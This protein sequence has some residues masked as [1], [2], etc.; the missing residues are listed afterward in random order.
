MNS[1][2]TAVLVSAVLGA[3]F[4]LLPELVP[5]FTAR[6]ETLGAEWKKA[7]RSWAG[8]LVLIVLVAL[9]YAAGIDFGFESTLTPQV[10]IDLLVSWATFVLSA[11]GTY[12]TFAWAYPRKRA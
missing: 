10:G 11:E 12:Q 2:Q 8:L 4:S 9:H 1:N 5:G 6:W 7:V 3:A